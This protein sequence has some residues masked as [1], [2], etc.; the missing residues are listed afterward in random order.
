[1]KRSKHSLSF[2]NLVSTDMG[3]LYPVAVLDALPGDTLQIFTRALIRVSPLVA[4]VMHPVSVRFHWWQVP[5]RLVWPTFESFITGGKNGTDAQTVPTVAVSGSPK[6]GLL[7]YMGVAPVSGLQVS[8][9]P[10]RAYNVIYNENYRDQDLIDEV[11]QDDLNI[12]RI[13]W[14]KDYFSGARPWPQKGPDVTLSLGTSAPVKGIQGSPVRWQVTTGQ[15]R[16]GDMDVKTDGFLAMGAGEAGPVGGATDGTNLVAD[17]SQA[18]AI[19][20]NDLRS[21]FAI[22]RYQEARA[23]FGSR[24]TEYLRYLGVRSSD[25]RLGR[26]EYLGGGKSVISFSEV[27]QTADDTTNQNPLGRLGGHGITA[28]RTR[29]FRRFIEEHSIVMCLMS[30]RPR[31]I[32]TNATAKM[33]FKQHK[34][35]F[36]QRELAHIGQQVI[37]NREVYAGHTTPTGTFGWADRYAEYKST[38]SLC[39]SEMRDNLNFWHLGRIFNSDPALNKSFVECEPSKRIHAVQT[40]DVLWN[41]VSHSIRARRM[42]PKAGFSTVR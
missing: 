15:G 26:P 23:R 1:M 7:D 40:N 24:Y 19:N 32:Y 8:A 34:E 5:Y 35:D 14:E 25:A 18:G 16:R 10:V 36:F 37:E 20:V 22:Q 13:A 28:I 42:V 11:G 4:P 21:A 6:K 12:H 3:L 38:P 41:M 17:L 30:V 2:Y 39:T 33:W 31:A 9:I 27:L 29:P